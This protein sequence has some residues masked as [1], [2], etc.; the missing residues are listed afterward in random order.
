MGNS[1]RNINRLEAECGASLKIGTFVGGDKPSGD[2]SRFNEND[3][4]LMVA[5]KAFGM[6]IDKPNV[7]FTINFNHPSSI[8]SFV[9]EAGRAGRD[10]NML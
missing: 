3:L 10:K 5:T 2:M 1:S 7:R 4:N 8:E 6:G 9:Q